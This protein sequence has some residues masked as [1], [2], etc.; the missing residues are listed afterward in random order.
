MPSAI[1]VYFVVCLIVTRSSFSMSAF[2]LFG[3]FCLAGGERIPLQ[4]KTTTNGTPI[5]IHHVF[6]DTTI[7]TLQ[8]PLQAKLHI[9][10]P[11][12]DVPL[13][14]ETVAFAVT[15][16]QITKQPPALLEAHAIIPYPGDPNNDT[17][18]EGIPGFPATF[19][20][21]VGPSRTSANAQEFAPDGQSKAFT[22]ELSDYVRN[23]MN[24]S[25][26][27]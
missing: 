4:K 8:G 27:Q 18:Q 10:S 21:G 20:V 23:A 1:C 7:S 26:V 19:F 12:G 14:S 24:S 25:L 2:I 15:R 17:Y 11:T 16:A 9:Y 5:T 3:N 13:P 22:M 6:Y